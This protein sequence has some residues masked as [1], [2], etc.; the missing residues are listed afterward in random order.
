MAAAFAAL[1]VKVLWQLSK[2]QAP[3]RAALDQLSLGNNTKVVS[4]FLCH[5]LLFSVPRSKSCST[6]QTVTWQLA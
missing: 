4:Y 5:M 2:A 6:L 1:P 3:D